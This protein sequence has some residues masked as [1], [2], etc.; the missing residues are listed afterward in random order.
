[1]Q[2]L[3]PPWQKGLEELHGN[4]NQVVQSFI[5]AQTEQLNAIEAGLASQ[6]EALALKEK[7]LSE[8]G[9]SISEV[10][11]VEARRLKDLGFFSVSDGAEAEDFSMRLYLLAIATIQTAQ[12]IG[13]SPRQ[14][15]LR[16]EIREAEKTEGFEDR[17][18]E[19]CL[20]CC[21]D[22]QQNVPCTDVEACAE[23]APKTGRFALIFSY[24]G[25]MGPKTLPF[26]ES[27]KSAAQKANKADLLILMTETDA[28]DMNLS[29]RE[30]L[31]NQGVQVHVVSWALP[32]NMKY[33][34]DENCYDAVAYFDNDIEVQ[35][36]ITPVLRCASTGNF[37]TTNGGLG[38]ALNVGFFAL[39]PHK[40]LLEAAENFAEEADYSE[41]TGWAQEGWKPCGGYY[42]GGECGQGFFHTLFYKRQAMLKEQFQKIGQKWNALQI[43]K[44]MW[45]YQT[46]YQCNNFDCSRVRV[47]HKP[48]QP[49]SDHRECLKSKYG[50]E[51][52]VSNV[53]NPTESNHSER[54][55]EPSTSGGDRYHRVLA[56]FGFYFPVHDQVEGVVEVLKSTRYFYPEAPIFVLQDGGSVD[57]GPL[58]KLQRFDCTF[59]RVLG[60][61]SRWNPHSWFARMRNATEFLQTEYV[62]YLEPDVKITRRH[63]VDPIH[64][65]GGVYD[66]F[67]PAM[68]A[69]TK[70]YLERLGSQ[71]EPCFNILWTHFGLCG[72]SYFR[73][74]AILDAFSPEH[75]MR[76]DWKNLRDKEGD[77]TMSS[78]F[79]M[80]VALSARGWTVYPWEESAQH[81]HDVPTDPSELLEFRKRW[82]ACNASAAFQHNHKE[83]YHANISDSERAVIAHFVDVPADTTCHG[84]VWYKDGRPESVMKVPSDPPDNEGEFRFPFTASNRTA[85]SFST[86]REPRTQVTSSL[87]VHPDYILNAGH[88]GLPV[89]SEQPSWLQKKD[90]L[91]VDARRKESGG[92]LILQPVF[93]EAGPLWGQPSASTRPR[94]LR[95]ILAT[96]RWHAR[97]YGHAMVIRWLPSQPQL[98]DW[99]RQQCG[100]FSEKDCTQ[101]NE[102]ENFNWE[103]H[104]MLQEY[105][106]SPQ[107]F[108][109]VMMLDADAALLR[110]EHNLLGNM[111]KQLA[112]QT[113]DV[114]FTNEDWLLNGAKRINGGVILARNS[115]FAKD[116]FKDT[117]DAHLMGPQGLSTWRIGIK[118]HQCSSNEQIC[119][120]D[121]MDASPEMRAQVLLASLSA[122]A[123]SATIGVVALYVIVESL[124]AT[125]ISDWVLMILAWRFFILWAII[126]WQ[127]KSFVMD[128]SI[129]RVRVCMAMD[130]ALDATLSIGLSIELMIKKV[131]IRTAERFLLFL[132]CILVRSHYH[133][134]LCGTDS[135]RERCL[136]YGF[137]K[138]TPSEK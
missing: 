66:N 15:L 51:M 126:H 90:I 43:D 35:G 78:D 73:S 87:L 137:G 85:C 16:H 56:R 28:A 17:K 18:L 96:N 117:C 120:N 133:V 61:N 114:F 38:E 4:L 106:E 105:L 92:M 93:M 99:Q 91:V 45:N 94:W 58:C 30:K 104:R 1:M 29:I 10:V 131:V 5:S 98:L 3:N 48:M 115:P 110:H 47:H 116:L 88:D 44:C 25:K 9:D 71:R 64:D 130:A 62:I 118:N 75:V 65:A 82:P 77:K 122:R 27:A 8:L 70:M 103:K 135:V 109:H 63:T 55:T 19:G 22:G 69:E 76:I 128:Q 21:N 52:L 60:E 50:R 80:L 112:I 111:A 125:R 79:A 53:S 40:L 134:L 81:F 33:T 46:S 121:A 101:R 67:N 12:S 41:Q 72:G 42:V 97:R 102:R 86:E 7:N 119:L 54:S 132:M 124:L 36:D 108:T 34:K 107:N 83:L 138:D 68:S 39:K 14:S 95:S 74:K 123:E 49:G 89:A 31:H 20:D 113:R 6:I 24:V 13:T 2:R 59:Q 100:N 136:V 11:E 32:P 37:L 129:S 84:C 127:T 57:F 26:L 23:M